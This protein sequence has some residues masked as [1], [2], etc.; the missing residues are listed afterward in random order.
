[1]V[2]F[3]SCT[4]I[5][6]CSNNSELS[7]FTSDGCSLFPDSSA[8]TKKDWCECCFQH[9]L[10]YWQGGTE[11]QREH[12]DI[13]LKQCV[14][15]KTEDEVLAKVMYDGVRLGGS[16]YFY[17]WYRWGYGWSYLDNS[18]G[19]YQALTDDELEQVKRLTEQYLADNKNNY[20][21]TR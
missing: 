16:P 17:N 19:K 21:D 20:C 1:M 14:L 15:E 3:F 13:E 4:T 5:L 8:I 2:C 7:P 11:P 9:D 18:R 12:A 6:A 10:A